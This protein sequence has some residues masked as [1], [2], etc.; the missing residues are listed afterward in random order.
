LPFR[1]DLQ[2]LSKGFGYM[3]VVV[4]A[5]A[6]GGL[7]AGIVASVLGFVAFN[8]FFIPP[9]ATFA[10]GRGEDVVVLFV[11]LGLSVLISALLA[12]AAGRRPAGGGR[13]AGAGSA[14]SGGGRRG[15]AP[16]PGRAASGGA[17]A[18]GWR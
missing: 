14:P 7:G 1:D 9:Y 12:R 15:R 4:A 16:T 13:G 2:P 11:F 6:V 18:L 8:F 5:A 17:G 3:A 10:V